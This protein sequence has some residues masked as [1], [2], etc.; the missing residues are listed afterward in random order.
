MK[1]IHVY[2]IRTSDHQI[3]GKR[4]IHYASQDGPI[5]VQSGFG[6]ITPKALHC[7]ILCFMT[8]CP[9]LRPVLIV[10]ELS[11][12][13]QIKL[14]DDNKTRENQTFSQIISILPPPSGG[15]KE[16]LSNMARV[17]EGENLST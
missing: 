1:T 11:P 4:C 6:F 10:S 3:M 8:S 2:R 9:Q 15:E 12:L 17:P 5:Y 7:T 14:K 13:A 16:G